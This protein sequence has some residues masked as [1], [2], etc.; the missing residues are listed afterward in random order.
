MKL[1]N[2]TAV[3]LREQS[4]PCYR[5][6]HFVGGELDGHQRLIRLPLEH[7]DRYT[8]FVPTEEMWAYDGR[9][10]RFVLLDDD[11]R[12]IADMIADSGLCDTPVVEAN[13]A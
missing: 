2:D 12:A 9:R 11:A 7:G 13:E 1:G 10:D 5:W 8:R 6:I 3:A 4:I